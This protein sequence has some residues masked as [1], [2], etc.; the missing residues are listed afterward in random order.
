LLIDD[1]NFLLLIFL[2][3][4]LKHRKVRHYGY[5]FEYGTNNVNPDN[6]LDEKIPTE[7]STVIERMLDQN[8]IAWTPEQLTVNQ[9]EPGQGKNLIF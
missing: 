6:P 1:R 4:A 7:C 5:Q 9:Y 3:Q 2:G 8:L